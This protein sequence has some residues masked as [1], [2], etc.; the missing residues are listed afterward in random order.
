MWNIYIIKNQSTRL[1]RCQDFKFYD[2]LDISFR[3]PNGA[4]Y[5]YLLVKL[6]LNP[7]RRWLVAYSNNIQATISAED[8]D[9]SGQEGSQLSKTDVCFCS[10]VACISSP[11]SIMKARQKGVKSSVAPGWLKYV[12]S[13]MTEWYYQV[14]YYNHDY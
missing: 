9:F 3:P 7:T 5:G 10:P 2:D 1:I 11:P 12:S 8:N 4:R 14:L 6:I 13:S